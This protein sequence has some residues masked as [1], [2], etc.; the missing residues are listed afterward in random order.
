MHRQSTHR[1][2]DEMGHEI[3]TNALSDLIWKRVGNG[4][5][6]DLIRR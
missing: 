2:G 4:E 3:L 5:I 6:H 1:E